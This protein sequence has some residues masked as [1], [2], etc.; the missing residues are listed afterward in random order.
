MDKLREL[1][2][3]NGNTIVIWTTDNGAWQ[4]VHPD[5]GYVAFAAAAKYCHF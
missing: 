4:D 3:Y 5:A 2:L 1:G